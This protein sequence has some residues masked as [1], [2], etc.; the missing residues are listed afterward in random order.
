MHK[1]PTAKRYHPAAKSTGASPQPMEG[2]K[3]RQMQK[4]PILR[5]FLFVGLSLPVVGRSPTSI[6]WV[7]RIAKVGER[8]ALYILSFSRSIGGLFDTL[9]RLDYGRLFRVKEIR[10]TTCLISDAH[11]VLHSARLFVSWLRRLQIFLLYNKAGSC[12]TNPCIGMVSSVLAKIAAKHLVTTPVQLSR[13][14]VLDKK[15]RSGLRGSF[16]NGCTRGGRTIEAEE[17]AMLTRTG[18]QNERD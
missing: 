14:T 3:G 15:N 11:I 16:V 13:A 6:R 4:L 8:N 7:G 18:S 12:F 5:W 17:N 10:K 1:Y 9:R 2:I